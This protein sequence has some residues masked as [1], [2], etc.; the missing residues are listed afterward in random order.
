MTDEP[1]SEGL[2]F[3]AFYVMLALG[4]L[5]HE[6]GWI[7]LYLRNQSVYIFDY[8]EYYK[9]LLPIADL[10]AWAVLLDHALLFSLCSLMILFPSRGGM[11]AYLMLPVIIGNFLIQGTKPANHLIFLVF[12]YLIHAL[13]GV[14]GLWRR[15]AGD[16]S[17]VE[18]RRDVSFLRFNLL[19]LLY[20]TYWAAAVAKLNTGFLDPAVTGATAFVW[21]PIS[22]FNYALQVLLGGRDHAVMRALWYGYGV[23][24]IASTLLVEFGL[25]VLL[26]VR[27]W[28]RYGLALG[29]L[30]HLLILFATAIDFSMV[31]LAIYPWI[32]SP[33][34]LRSFL[35]DHVMRPA[36]STVLPAVLLGAYLC[37]ANYK[38]EFLTGFM[39]PLDYY[40]MVHTLGLSYLLFAMIRFAREGRLRRADG[41]PALP[42]DAAPVCV[43]GTPSAGLPR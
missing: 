33:T 38:F 6:I 34:E 28:R 17:G 25:P 18:A 4:T 19:L 32:L 21:K 16:P 5:A 42:V 2:R 22:P 39:N 41:A 9:L 27:R 11:F 12:V 36:R 7:G 15:I 13:Y 10:P 3:R 8:Y 40:R 31:C 26:L 23:I 37:V 43:R 1:A 29:L 20:S 35:R 24:G 14:L 30:F